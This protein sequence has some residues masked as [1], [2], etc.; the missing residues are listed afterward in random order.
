MNPFL[1][2]RAGAR[3][4]RR[5]YL[6]QKVASAEK[7]LSDYNPDGTRKQKVAKPSK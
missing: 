6:K 3:A 7:T 1:M 5:E 4:F 2:I